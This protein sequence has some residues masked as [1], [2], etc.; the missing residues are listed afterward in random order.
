MH[1]WL[2]LLELGQCCLL[3][4]HRRPVVF[5]RHGDLPVVPDGLREHRRGLRRLHR[6]VR[7][8]LLQERGLDLVLVWLELHRLHAVRVGRGLRNDRGRLR[9]VYMRVGLR[10][11]LIVKDL[12]CVS[13]RDCRQVRS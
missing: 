6:L 1:C 10:L 11:G 4:V 9:A 3:T 7:R 2:R 5:G 8:R 12:R 13:V